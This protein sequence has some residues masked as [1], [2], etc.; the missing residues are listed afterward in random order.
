MTIRAFWNIL[1][2]ILGIYLVVQGVNVIAP[3]IGAFAT[4]T[5]TEDSIYYIA[6]TLSVLVAYFFIL[7]LFVFKTSWIIDK[8]QLEKGFEEE[9]IDLKNDSAAI[10]TIAVIVI[11]GIMFIESLPELS[12]ELSLFIKREEIPFQ[13]N[14]NIGWTIFFVAKA[15]LGYLLMTNC[16]PIV[17]FIS[18][19]SANNEGDINNAKKT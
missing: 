14:P 17:A 9:R 7:W 3:Y 18:R 4:V 2:K 16:K 10:M 12:R 11:G 8:L 13:E 5:S 19:K 1:L 15:I 6:V